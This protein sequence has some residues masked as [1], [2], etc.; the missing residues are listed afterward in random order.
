MLKKYILQC[1]KYFILH[2]NFYYHQSQ[3]LADYIQNAQILIQRIF[4]ISENTCE[5]KPYKYI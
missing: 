1:Y 5:N 4:F 3:T 2:E